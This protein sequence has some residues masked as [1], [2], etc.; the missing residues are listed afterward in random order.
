MFYL[1]EVGYSETDISF[2]TTTIICENAHIQN[3]FISNVI[4]CTY[5]DD[6]VLI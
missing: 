1:F 2:L 5:F 3:I 4:H 6:F